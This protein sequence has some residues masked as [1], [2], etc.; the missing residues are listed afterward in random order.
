MTIARCW[1]CELNY[2]PSLL[3]ER[4][5]GNQILL[6][7]GERATL[8][9][10]WASTGESCQWADWVDFSIH[11]SKP[12]VYLFVPSNWPL[13]ICSA[14]K[15]GGYRREVRSPSM[16]AVKDELLRV[17]VTPTVIYR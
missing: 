7:P 12:T 14:V 9:L 5:P 2:T 4:Q 17:S 11:W 15:S 10:Q 6:A 1:L 3:T 16:G 8:D 13:H